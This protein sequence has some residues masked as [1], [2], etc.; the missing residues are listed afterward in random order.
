MFTNEQVQNLKEL[1]TNSAAKGNLANSGMVL[2]NGKVIGAA[3]SWVVT[4]NDATAHSER[5]LVTKICNAKKSNYT[6]GLIMVTVVEPCIMC[7]SACAQAGY[8]EIQYIIP[9]QRYVKKIPWIIDSVLTDKQKL[10]SQFTNP[11]T[12]THLKEYEEE[13]C[14]VFEKVMSGFLGK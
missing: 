13:F 14:V 2:E 8:S 3:E 7:M 1:M 4:D 5:M 9:A 6:P 10:A 11:L 12:L